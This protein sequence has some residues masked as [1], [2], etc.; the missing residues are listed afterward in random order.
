MLRSNDNAAGNS[1]SETTSRDRLNCLS[2]DVRRVKL[3]SVGLNHCLEMPY[4]LKKERLGSERSNKQNILMHQLVA[5]I[6]GVLIFMDMDTLLPKAPNLTSP[7]T[8][9][10]LTGWAA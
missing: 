10:T 6:Y 2:K 1:I 7:D 3:N 4:V 8:T 9:E 5:T